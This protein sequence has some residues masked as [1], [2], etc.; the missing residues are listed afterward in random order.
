MEVTVSTFRAQLKRWL[1]RARDGE[2]V[3]VTDHGLPIAR[4]VGVGRLTNLERLVREGKVTLPKKQSGRP[5]T[6]Y[7]RVRASK[8]V[9]PL[10][11]EQRD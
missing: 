8:P 9:S 7:P 6:S 10:I 2:E 3:V 4:I 5:P 1:E 11:S